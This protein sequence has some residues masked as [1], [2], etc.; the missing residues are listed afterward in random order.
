MQVQKTGVYSDEELPMLQ[1][2]RHQQHPRPSQ[3]SSTFFV[4]YYHQTGDLNGG[5]I[6]GWTQPPGLVSF[7]TSTS[8]LAP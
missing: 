1:E 2:K 4:A 3:G 7:P 5:Q 6:G 8:S